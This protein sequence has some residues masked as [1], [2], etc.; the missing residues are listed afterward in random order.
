ML[1]ADRP[2]RLMARRIRA[3]QLPLLQLHI[4]CLQEQVRRR[5]RAELEVERA[6]R[7][8]GDAR[9]NGRSG[10]EVRGA[11]VEFLQ[12][13]GLDCAIEVVFGEC[14]RAEGREDELCRSPLT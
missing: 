14:G 12:R 8:D 9:G 1:Q 7:T 13:C 6:V 4:R 2:H 5:R 10:D 11:G 3:L